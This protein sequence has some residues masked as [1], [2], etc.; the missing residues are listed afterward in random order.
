MGEKPLRI[1]V[2]KID[3]F[4]KIYDRIKYLITKKNITDSIN[5]IFSR[6][7]IASHNSIFKYHNA[8]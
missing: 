4:I 7:R 1:W 3:G 6:I 2:D 8:L 5:R